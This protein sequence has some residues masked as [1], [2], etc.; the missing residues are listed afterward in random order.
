MAE[1]DD[2][3]RTAL[4]LPAT[5]E[6]TSREGHRVWRVQGRPFA[7]ERPLR[8]ADLAELGDAA[9]AGPV[10]ALH[11]P[12]LGAR[13][14]LLAD[15]PAVFLTTSHVDGYPVVLARLD[16]V[17]VPE[18]TELIGEAWACRAPRRLAAEHRPA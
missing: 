4:A 6:G 1:W 7:R 3:R 16:E 12:D 13:A 2:V 17:A 15:D 8:R 11:V 14:A 10:L 5:T 18:L 9:P